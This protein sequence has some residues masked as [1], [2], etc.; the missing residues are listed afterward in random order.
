ME[1]TVQNGA[2]KEEP[3]FR[4]SSFALIIQLLPWCRSRGGTNRASMCYP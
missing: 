4:G 2:K 1:D 3:L